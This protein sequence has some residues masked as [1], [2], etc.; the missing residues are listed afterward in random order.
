MNE[1]TRNSYI[2]SAL[3]APHNKLEVDEK[4]Y[5]WQHIGSYPDGEDKLKMIGYIDSEGNIFKWKSVLPS[6]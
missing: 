2:A 6:G 5:I 4:G 1:T 3:N